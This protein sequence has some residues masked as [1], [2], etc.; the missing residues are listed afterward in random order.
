MKTDNSLNVN[1]LYSPNIK[2]KN[3][4]GN[5]EIQIEVTQTC[6]KS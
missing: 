4:M 5:I 6:H 2:H 3:H 1:W